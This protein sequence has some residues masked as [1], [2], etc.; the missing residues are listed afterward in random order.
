MPPMELPEN[1]T[2]RTRRT[3]FKT[4]QDGKDLIIEG[5]FIVF[6]QPYYAY[7]D[8]EEVISPHALDGADTSDVRA[9]VDH[10]SHLVLGRSTANTLTFSVDNI[11]VFGSIR[12]NAADTD[13]TNLYARVQRG[14]VD[15]ASFGFE[16]GTVAYTELPG[17]RYR[18]EIQSIKKLWELSVCTFPAYEQTYVGARGRMDEDIRKSVVRA[19][20]EKLKRRFKHHA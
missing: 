7:E 14:D 17:G 6:N 16:E 18:R 19:A 5:Y 8:M 10:L 15:Q 4:R 12:I 3:D 9:L 11:G 13:A 1:L 20:K 2:M